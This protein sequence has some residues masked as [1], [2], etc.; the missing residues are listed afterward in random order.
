MD[1]TK[2]KI[3]ATLVFAV[4]NDGNQRKVLLAQKVRK[5]IVNCFNGFGG[6]LNKKETPRVCAIRELKA[7]S[8][9][10]AMK[11]DL[12]FV[13]VVT[14]HNQRKDHSQFSVRVFIFTLSKWRGKVKTKEDEMKNPKWFKTYRLPLKRMA[15]G[16]KLFVPQIFI[17]D[18]SKELLHGDIW[19]SRNQKK[20]LR[21]VVKWVA[22]TGDIN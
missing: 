13:G 5:L 2:N 4:K 9:L 6:S 18:H 20:L 21:Y 14:F 10:T 3:D 11:K 1:L 19:Y 12:E 15:P 22:R 17:G 7:E 16:D 8:G